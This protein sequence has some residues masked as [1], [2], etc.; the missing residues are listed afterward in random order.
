MPDLNDI[1]DMAE[2][3]I[4][5]INRVYQ[6]AGVEIPD[7]QYYCIGGQGQTVHDCE[8]LTVSWDQAYSGLPEAE[9]SIPARCD[10]VHTAR[11]VIEVVREYSTIRP[12][13][14]PNTGQVVA[15]TA[16]R[17]AAYRN[18]TAQSQ[19]DKVDPE[20]MKREARTQM[21]DAVLL[22]RAGLIAGE[23]TTTNNAVVDVA[24]GP[25]SG[26]FQAVIMNFTAGLGI[27]PY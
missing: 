17:P 21:Q 20:I 27:D 15:P 19:I 7:L 6:E 23:G 24:A 5:T 11:F 13:V 3:L 26:N 2:H 9:A 22:L 18:R 16:N 10:Q 14:D 25:P 8:Q 12:Y 4:E 1:I